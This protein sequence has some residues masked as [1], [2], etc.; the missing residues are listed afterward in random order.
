MDWYGLNYTKLNKDLN[1]FDM[2]LKYDSKI[3]VEN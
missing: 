3:N 2:I 1:D